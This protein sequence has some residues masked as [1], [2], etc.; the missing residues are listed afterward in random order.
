ME[1]D[2]SQIG[3][4]A[5]FFDQCRQDLLGQLKDALGRPVPHTVWACLWLSDTESLER[6]IPLLK[7]DPTMI[8]PSFVDN[9]FDK[10]DSNVCLWRI[11]EQVFFAPSVH[12]CHTEG[13]FALQP[14]KASEDSTS[15]RVK[16][17]WLPK[18]STPSSTLTDIMDV[19]QFPKISV[20]CPETFQSV[21][22]STSI[23]FVQVK[24]SNSPL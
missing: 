10:I 23:R 4:Q 16:L 24:K 2:N 5:G 1:L 18:R 3:P 7:S 11:S 8:R 15:L 13:L 6:M 17:Y 19:L 22:S 9:L 20:N 14:I 21:M 12:R